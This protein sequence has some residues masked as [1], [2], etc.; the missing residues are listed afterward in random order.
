[1]L[2]FLAIALVTLLLTV[3]A[4]D[5]NCLCMHK[6]CRKWGTHVNPVSTVSSPLSLIPHQPALHSPTAKSELQCCVLLL[7]RK[8]TGNTCLFFTVVGAGHD[9]SSKL[10]LEN[11]VD[12][13]FS[14]Y[15]NGSGLRECVG[16]CVGVTGKMGTLVRLY[17]TL[18]KCQRHP[19]LHEAETKG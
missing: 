13:I 5:S 15:I 14:S 1:M 18:A 8:H 2:D 4:L 9:R 17:Y 16:V 10:Y 12:V 6:T 3:Q 7:W 19:I 11:T